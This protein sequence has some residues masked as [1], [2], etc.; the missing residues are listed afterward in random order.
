VIEV[1]VRVV[2][3]VGASLPIGGSAA[4]GPQLAAA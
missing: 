4:H 3:A 2:E 1:P